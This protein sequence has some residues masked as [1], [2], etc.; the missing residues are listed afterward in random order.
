M[1]IGLDA[2]TLATLTSELDAATAVTAETFKGARLQ[3][4]KS[5]KEALFPAFKRSSEYLDAKRALLQ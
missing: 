5:V 1:E 4:I 3:A 2:R